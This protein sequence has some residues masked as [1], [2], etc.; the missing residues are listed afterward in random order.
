MSLTLILGSRL[1]NGFWNIICIFGLSLLASPLDKF[2][3]SLPNTLILPEVGLTIPA[4]A[5]P[6][7]VLPEPDSPTSPNTS[8]LDILNDTPSTALIYIGLLNSP[9]PLS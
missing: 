4:I 5:F 9:P 6:T 1:L 7:L 3:I 8:P 2:I